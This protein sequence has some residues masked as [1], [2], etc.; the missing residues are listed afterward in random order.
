MNI[1]KNMCTEICVYELLKDVRCD[2][3]KV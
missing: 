3:N 1:N 2:K